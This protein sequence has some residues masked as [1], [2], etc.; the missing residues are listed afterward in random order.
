MNPAPVAR[1]RESRSGSGHGQPPSLA[2]VQ[3]SAAPAERTRERRLLQTGVSQLRYRERSR[4][5]GFRRSEPRPSLKRTKFTL[6][7]ERAA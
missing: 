1:P 7:I 5:G 3:V 2:N 4:K 6:Q